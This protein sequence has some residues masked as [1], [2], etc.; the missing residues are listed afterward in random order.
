M[1]EKIFSCTISRSRESWLKKTSTCMPYL[2][3][4]AFQF[5][6][7]DVRLGLLNIRC[8]WGVGQAWVHCKSTNSWGE[9]IFPNSKYINSCQNSDHQYQQSQ[10]IW[11]IL[12]ATTDIAHA[13]VLY[14]NICL[15]Y[16]FSLMFNC[17]EKLNFML[18]I[19][20]LPTICQYIGLHTFTYWDTIHRCIH[21]SDISFQNNQLP[22]NC[23]RK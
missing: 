7:E 4:V 3:L 8:D 15:L 5:P 21:I 19:C 12:H 10:H 1:E 13:Q 9:V 17:S 20:L 14:V 11:L 23:P 22:T 18:T 16:K 6:H 2:E